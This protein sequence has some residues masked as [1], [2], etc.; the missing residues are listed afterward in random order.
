MTLRRRML[1][2]LFVLALTFGVFGAG[3][4]AVQRN[5]LIGRLDAQLAGYAASP[6]WW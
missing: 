2:A 5:Y 1:I 6:C 3:V 4:V